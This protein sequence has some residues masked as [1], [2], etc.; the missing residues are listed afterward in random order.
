MDPI[1]S[2]EVS[3]AGLASH[4]NKAEERRKDAANILVS[5]FMKKAVGHL[6][7][8]LPDE[9][10]LKTYKRIEI[11]LDENELF[12]QMTLQQLLVY[13][14]AQSKPCF[15]VQLKGESNTIVHGT[16]LMRAM[17]LHGHRRHPLTRQL[18]EEFKIYKSRHKVPTEFKFV[19]DEKSFPGENQHWAKFIN[20]CSH[21]LSPLE[22]G[23]EQFYMAEY[24]E[25][26]AK[27]NSKKEVPYLCKSK[28]WLDL[29]AK[30]GNADANLKLA[31]WYS[32]GNGIAYADVKKVNKYLKAY[33]HSIDP[34]LAKNAPLFSAYR[35]ILNLFEEEVKNE[36]KSE[37]D[38][39]K[40]VENQRASSP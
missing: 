7:E 6:I 31:K 2:T 25:R 16:S 19:C 23:Q 20:A 15:L 18:I 40:L 37:L 36:I 8:P 29:A 30:N 9:K 14:V 38:F 17:F 11:P 12:S 28:F 1:Q 22:L 34:E 27:A 33:V 39:C 32:E 35:Q 10:S 4:V 5:L 24:Y 26:L 3:P 21:D 13:Q